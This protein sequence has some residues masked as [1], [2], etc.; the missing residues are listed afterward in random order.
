MECS[1]PQ[2][3]DGTEK[4]RQEHRQLQG[5]PKESFPGCENVADNFR[6]KR[7]A[8]AMKQGQLQPAG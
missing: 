1:E 2:R 3:T 6:Q 5:S 4:E 7:Q 8:T